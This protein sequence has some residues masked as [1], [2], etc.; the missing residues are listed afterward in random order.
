MH[1]LKNANYLD[2]F[3]IWSFS[4]REMGILSQKFASFLCFF[5]SLIFLWSTI[6][7]QKS[8]WPHAKLHFT[9][10]LSLIHDIRC[11]SL[12]LP[13]GMQRRGCPPSDGFVHWLVGCRMVGPLVRPSCQGYRSDT[14][15]LRWFFLLFD[16]LLLI[17]TYVLSTLVP[18]ASKMS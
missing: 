10:T 14:A 12:C 2:T 15:N 6:W 8:I 11:L 1:V 9:V 13:I 4:C 17:L 16:F 5:G 7:K 3:K 18:T